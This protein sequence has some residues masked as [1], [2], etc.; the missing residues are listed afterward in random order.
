MPPRPRFER[1]GR[2]PRRAGQGTLEVKVGAG[3]SAQHVFVYGTL[4]GATGHPMADLLQPARL[5]GAGSVAGRLY[6]LGAYPGMVNART[7]K[8]RVRGQV[9]RLLKPNLTLVRLDVYEGCGGVAGEYRRK[10]V[11][12]RLDSGRKLTAW[13]YF[14]NGAVA[15]RVRIPSGDYLQALRIPRLQP[16]KMS[17]R[18]R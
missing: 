6:D 9:Y 10:R 5:V 16:A 12:V 1:H 13:A 14:F 11:R 7:A 2:V 4:H 18:W 3:S 8:D 15:A 17:K